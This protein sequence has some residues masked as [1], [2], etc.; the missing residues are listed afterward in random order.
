MC[1]AISFEIKI[2]VT[3]YH[4][5]R[6]SIFICKMLLIVKVSLLLCL[7]ALTAEFVLCA[8][9]SSKQEAS[10]SDAP[11]ATQEVG[12]ESHE[13]Y[14]D[15]LDTDWYTIDGELFAKNLPYLDP[16]KTLRLLKLARDHKTEVQWA[17]DWRR[18]SQLVRMSEHTIAKC[19]EDYY[20]SI[21]KLIE[22]QYYKF[23]RIV[24][25]LGYC[26]T[27]QLEFCRENFN[28]MVL[29]SVNNLSLAD[30]TDV[31][32]LIDLIIGDIDLKSIQAISQ[33]PT[34]FAILGALNFLEIKNGKINAQQ[35]QVY[36]ENYSPL[37]QFE[38]FY[39]HWIGLLCMEL[40]QK[41][42]NA[43][44][45]MEEAQPVLNNYY[46]MEWMSRV[47]ICKDI[48]KS[49]FTEAVYQ[50]LMK[51]STPDKKKG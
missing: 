6:V 10:S 25:Y 39:I 14:L 48:N 20:K 49:H 2:P 36:D 34:E 35:F 38:K 7:L 22:E 17:S 31:E 37:E 29:Q 13:A 43:I 24:D 5:L 47:R 45:T 41:F 50:E 21:A 15:R 51:R 4:T 44:F 32:M 11:P 19:C 16:E 33:I 12:Q 40:E 1:S 42:E 27:K 23:N 8:G 9:G 30:R 28:E 26:R 18:S 3:Q 46:A